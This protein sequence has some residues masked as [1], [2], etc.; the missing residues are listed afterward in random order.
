[1]SGSMGLKQWEFSILSRSY[2]PILVSQNEN[3]TMQRHRS[4]SQFAFSKQTCT[5]INILNSKGTV[6]YTTYQ[7]QYLY[8]YHLYKHLY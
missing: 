7:V 5:R 6:L 2:P 4:C 8:H 1:M 3:T